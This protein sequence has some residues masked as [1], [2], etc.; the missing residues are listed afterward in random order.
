MSTPT[1][2][3][4]G[5]PTS[6]SKTACSPPAKW[7]IQFDRSGG[8][9]GLDESLTLDS[10]GSLEVQSERPPTKVEMSVSQAQ[11]DA[12]TDLLVQA[13]PFVNDST[14]GDGCA[15]CF[16]YDLNIQIDGHIYSVQAT[17]VTMSEDLHPLI[18]ALSQLA[19]NIKQ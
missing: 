5:T 15:D 4:V 7:S 14:K 19:Q 16:V 13:C 6:S 1:S 2:E 12:I 10:G 9:A 17:D 3:P 11:V 18:D 8:F